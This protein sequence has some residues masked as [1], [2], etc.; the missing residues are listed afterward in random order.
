MDCIRLFWEAKVPLVK[1]KKTEQKQNI[2][3][4]AEVYG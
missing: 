3:F 2:L 1:D 4:I